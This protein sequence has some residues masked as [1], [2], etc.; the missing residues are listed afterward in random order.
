M[1]MPC[2]KSPQGH[3]SSN[4]EVTRDPWAR[5]LMMSSEHSLACR[6]K[7]KTMVKTRVE[8]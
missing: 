4:Q 5:G 8:E 1:Y 2:E 3:P 6:T 7:A